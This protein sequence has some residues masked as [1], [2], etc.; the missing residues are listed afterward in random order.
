M[1]ITGVCERVQVCAFHSDEHYH[2]NSDRDGKYSV[3]EMTQ[4]RDFLK[5][6]FLGQFDTDPLLRPAWAQ[7]CFHYW[8]KVAFVS[9]KTFR[10]ILIR[11]TA[12]R[13]YQQK[14]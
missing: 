14:L 11:E 12:T 5:F 2:R 8:L 10:V 7:L 13:A 9:S 4:R 1:I 6:L 3:L